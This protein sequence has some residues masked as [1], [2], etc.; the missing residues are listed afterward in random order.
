MPLEEMAS[1]IPYELY[2]IIQ[3]ILNKNAGQLKVSPNLDEPRWNQTYTNFLTESKGLITTATVL[4]IVG[5]YRFQLSHTVKPVP[6]FTFNAIAL[7]VRLYYGPYETPIDPTTAPFYGICTYQLDDQNHD[8]MFVQTK[9]IIIPNA[10]T[11]TRYQLGY[12]VGSTDGIGNN[13]NISFTIDDCFFTQYSGVQNVVI[14]HPLTFYITVNIPTPFAPKPPQLPPPPADYYTGL[15]VSSNGSY[16]GTG[17]ITW[18]PG[19]N[20]QSNYLRGIGFVYITNGSSD[21]PPVFP[22]SVM[23][24]DGN[25]LQPW[26]TVQVSNPFS[27]YSRFAYY[28]SPQFEQGSFQSTWSYVISSTT[29][30]PDFFIYAYY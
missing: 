4:P 14:N 25:E 21:I 2:I 23:D 10:D 30:L 20:S 9:S 8:G 16:Y 7:E 18:G 17:S 28:F 1:I 29:Q 5:S 11:S 27:Q 19:W 13:A 6:G 15:Y 3:S 24:T 26:R 22:Y 12:W